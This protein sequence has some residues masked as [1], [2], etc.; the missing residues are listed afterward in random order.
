MLHEE[1]GEL[2]DVVMDEVEKSK[3]IEASACVRDEEELIISPVGVLHECHEVLGPR[4]DGV[5]S[6]AKGREIL[7]PL[8]ELFCTA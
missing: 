3:G 2:E 1:D 7:V 5:Q 8:R 6:G 4:R